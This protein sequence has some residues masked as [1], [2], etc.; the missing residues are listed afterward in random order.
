MRSSP[1]LKS[2]GTHSNSTKIATSAS[3]KSIPTPEDNVLAIRIE[4]DTACF[5]ASIAFVRRS[6]VS[7][8]PQQKIDV[9][10]DSENSFVEASRIFCAVSWWCEKTTILT[11][12]S[13]WRL[14]RSIAVLIFPWEVIWTSFLSASRDW[15]EAYSPS[16]AGFSLCATADS[17]V[18]YLAKIDLGTSQKITFRSDFGKWEATSERI[19]L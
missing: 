4:G 17:A 13:T 12:R 1:C 3:A 10:D 5:Q 11:W 14:M 2:A 16:R 8:P 15:N 9:V 19:F 7:H 6:C 18:W